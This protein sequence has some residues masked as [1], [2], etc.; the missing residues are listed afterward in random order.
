MKIRLLF[1]VCFIAITSGCFAQN[2]GTQDSDQT[3]V[4]MNNTN[5]PVIPSGRII[6]QDMKANNPALFTQYQNGKKQQMTGMILACVGGGLIG[7]SAFAF[8]MYDITKNPSVFDGI[9]Y[10]DS[11]TWLIT[12]IVMSSAGVV[13]GTIG[14]S[15]NFRGKN[16]KNR[17]FQDFKNQHYSS[18]T[19]SSYFQMNVYPN[20]IGIAY[21]F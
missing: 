18:Q 14:L 21:V 9:A 15:N 6:L 5:Q 4:K 8:I 19:P 2:V 13:I 7:G 16:S 20:R 17:A 3:T 10:Y 1:V 11:T 12:G